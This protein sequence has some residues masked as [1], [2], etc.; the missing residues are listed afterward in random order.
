MKFQLFDGDL[1]KLIDG[2]HSE[3]IGVGD[4]PLY[5]FRNSSKVIVG[6][7]TELNGML[8]S[9]EL[10]R[11]H[12]LQVAQLSGSHSEV[13]YARA[14]LLAD[15][16]LTWRATRQTACMLETCLLNSLW[17]TIV[18]NL[19]PGATEEEL[20]SLCSAMFMSVDA[21][22]P[23][24]VPDQLWERLEPLLTLSRGSI[25]Q[26]VRESIPDCP[27]PPILSEVSEEGIPSH[28]FQNAL[29]RIRKLSRQE[30]RIAYLLS[31]LI[32]RPTIAEFIMANYT[33]KAMLCNS[34]LLKL[35]SEIRMLKSRG[36]R[37]RYISY[38]IRW[39]FTNSF[40]LGRGELLYNLALGLGKYPTV[41]Q[42]IL[43]KVN[44]SMAFNVWQYRHL[45]KEVIAEQNAPKDVDQNSR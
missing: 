28:E 36:Q 37:E 6:T 34:V 23:N 5:L 29:V 43:D 42:S 17:S 41:A 8:A 27:K 35:R 25:V 30:R 19:K 24:L 14:M 7:A 16:G 4:A 40:P 45:I 13:R 31:E 21:A 12:A 20:A 2:T 3:H 10:Q 22:L 32:E 15:G 26:C 9:A 33:D 39:M 1:S 38:L 11:A 18:E 44:E